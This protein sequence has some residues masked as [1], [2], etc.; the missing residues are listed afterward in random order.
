MTCTKTGL[1]CF[2]YDVHKENNP[3]V[4]KLNIV[5]QRL[6]RVDVSLSHAP[7]LSLLLVPGRFAGGNAFVA[8]KA[9][10]AVQW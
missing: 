1:P 6:S 4:K 8:Y 2:V 9:L 3:V 5:F 10:F 7:T